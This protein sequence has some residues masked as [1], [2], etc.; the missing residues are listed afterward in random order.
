MFR[1]QSQSL[2][3]SEYEPF[4]Q[5]RWEES[6]IFHSDPLPNTVNWV[7]IELPPFA[8]GS[9][10]LGHVRNYV[11]GDVS[12]RFRRMAGYNV[13]YTSGFDSYGLPNELAARENGRHPQN[14]AEDVMDEMRRDFLRLGLSH[15]TRRIIGYHEPQY[16]RWVQWVFLKLY[17]QGLAYKQEG[18]VNWCE[19]CCLTLADS[20]VEQGNCWRC[21]NKVEIRTMSQWLVNE[22]VFAD[23]MLQ[24]LAELKNWPAKIK[25]IHRDWIGRREGATVRFN[26]K[27]ANEL[28][29]SVF[30]PHPVLLPGAGFIALAPIHPLVTLL[31]EKGLISAEIL[32][33]IENFRKS[34]FS[35]RQLLTASGAPA[36]LP[37]LEL[38][39]SALNP[40]T[41]SELPLIISPALDLRTNNGITVGFPAHIRADNA[42]AQQF[43][44]EPKQ[45]LS[46]TQTN[47]DKTL[48]D[49]D[50]SWIML[51][52]PVLKGLPASEAKAEIIK[53][54]KHN[55]KGE[56]SV[57]YRLRDWN[58]ARQ[59]YWGPPVPIIFCPV[60]GT[61]P[62][63]EDSLPVVLPYD[64][65]FNGDG[66]P[67]EKSPEFVHTTCFKCGSAARRE[68]DTLEAYSSPWWY[69][70]NCK[71]MS[72][73]Y[74]FDKE[75]ASWWHPVD[76]MIGG[77]D[78]ARTC[79]FHIRMMTRA[80]QRADIVEYDEPVDTLLAIGMVKAN[81]KKMSKSAGNAVDPFSLIAK[82]GTDTLR[83]S[84]MAGAAPE[85]DLNW[86]DVNL[87]QIF[88]FLNKVWHFG[89]LIAAQDIS[90][91][92]IYAS[93]QIDENY[94][95]SR[96]LSHQLQTAIQRTTEA[97]CHNNYHLA[98]SNL[99]FLFSKI[100]TYFE[101]AISRRGALDERDVNTV[102][103]A[104]DS[105]LRMLAPLCPHISE[106]LWAEC[107]GEGFIAEADWV[108]NII[109]A[110]K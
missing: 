79:F 15:D 8:N 33:D 51:V 96:K 36:D 26:L 63:P 10:H 46:F 87:G 41:G 54:L 66:N 35:T 84:L 89:K 81:G 13:L 53:I 39:V 74:P 18:L 21:G 29:F 60:C 57:S 100:E 104:F 30:I 9:L 94:S 82:Y 70:W 107:H 99:I 16:Y 80:L 65:D 44:I 31:S 85:S 2:P 109:Q 105:F 27:E 110:K 68:T 59:R 55:E 73:D 69:H 83:L 32:K 62:V 76:L 92:K 23:E 45:V 67:L 56:I 98:A 22:S 34:G 12:A 108:K 43:G 106:Q 28:E 1:K 37:S 103:I 6:K 11:M 64:V 52:P 7:V 24:G 97:Y 101:E 93:A 42:F 17:E 90:F 3:F 4:W 102:T 19:S 72:T 47:V 40:I 48:F 58:I 50:E 86:S 38:G 77:E 20:L 25:R 49:W 78:Q 5:K 95:L 61:L 71:R 88:A 75:E 14:L 91:K